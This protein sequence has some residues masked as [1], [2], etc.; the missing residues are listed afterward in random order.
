MSQN[1]GVAASDQSPVL[2]PL[3]VHLWSAEVDPSRPYA[4]AVFV[5][6]GAIGWTLLAVGIF[7]VTASYTSTLLVIS[8]ACICVQ[9]TVWLRLGGGLILLWPLSVRQM[10][11]NMGLPEVVVMATVYAVMALLCAAVVSWVVGGVPPIGP[12]REWLVTTASAC[13]GVALIAVI[14]AVMVDLSDPTKR[15][16]YFYY[17][18]REQPSFWDIEEMRLIR[19]MVPWIYRL[20]L[21][22]ATVAV[23]AVIAARTT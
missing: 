4:V 23:F 11:R 19:W 20:G 15:K 7:V 1:R 5:G 2:G 10:G 9:Y 21:A 13:G 16:G 22:S 18:K 3:P 8:L 17:R 12:G 14:L 6:F